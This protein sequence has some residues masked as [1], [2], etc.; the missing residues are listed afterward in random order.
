MLL[1]LLLLI[2][3]LIALWSEKIL[4]VISIIK[5][6]QGLFC[7]PRCDLY[8]RMFHMHFRGKYILLLWGE[9]FH[10]YLLGLYGLVYHLRP[11][12]PC[13]FFCLDDLFF[14]VNEVLKSA[15]LLCYCPSLLLWPLVV[16][17][18]IGVPHIGCIYIH[19]YIYIYNCVYIYIYLYI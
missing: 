3:S 10:R 5:I 13:W 16:A 19:I 15:I 6:Y 11:V 12:V 2:F 4:E 17:L 1:L 14:A 9:K 18:Y 7:G 8:W